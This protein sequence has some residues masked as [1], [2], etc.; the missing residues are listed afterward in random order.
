MR[1]FSSTDLANRTGDVLA[2]A[3]R[4]TVRIKRHGTARFVVM[5][6]ERFEE[7]AEQGRTQ[8][9]IH[10]ADMSDD[11]AD[12]LLAALEADEL[13]QDGNEDPNGRAGR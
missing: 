9:A 12:T 11:E 4:D 5:S 1:E 13:A 8:R 10:V 2:A 7:M 3:A 6:V